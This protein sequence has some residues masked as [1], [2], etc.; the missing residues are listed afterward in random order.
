MAPYE[1][2]MSEVARQFCTSAERVRL[3]K[4]LLQLRAELV[5]LGMLGLQWIDG[6]F[7]EDVEKLRGRAPGDID[8]VT[9]L[10]RP[11]DARDDTTWRALWQAN[12]RVFDSKQAKTIFGCEAFYIDATYPAI[13]VADQVTYWF[14]LFTH[15]RVSNL[16]KGVV[17]VPLASDDIAAAKLVDSLVFSERT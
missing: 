4:G 3:F 8:V 6:S 1:A 5:D 15:Q 9:L 2:S 13:L 10:V 16:W 7:C 17:E 12:Q 11:K 14:G